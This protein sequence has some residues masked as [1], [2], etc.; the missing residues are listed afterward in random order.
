MTRITIRLDRL[1]QRLPASPLRTYDL[2]RLT[3]EQLDRLL[4]LRERIELVGAEG[5]TPEELEE[6]AEL[7]AVLEGDPACPAQD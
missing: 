5:L 7:A 3:D 4:E 6:L 1:E 2:S